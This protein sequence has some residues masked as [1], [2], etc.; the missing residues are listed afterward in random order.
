MQR[1]I[2]DKVCLEQNLNPWDD[3]LGVKSVDYS[4]DFHSML[5]KLD[6]SKIFYDKGVMDT[7]LLRYILGMSKIFYQGQIDNI[8][9]KKKIIHLQLTL[10]DRF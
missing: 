7:D 5:K 10:I 6:K 9:T 8:M 4:A 1:D 2:T 3:S